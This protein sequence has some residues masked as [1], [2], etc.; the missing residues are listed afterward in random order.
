MACSYENYGIF[1]PAKS[2]IKI[3]DFHHS[4]KKV[5]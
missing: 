5:P 1:N 3:F 2:R 4:G